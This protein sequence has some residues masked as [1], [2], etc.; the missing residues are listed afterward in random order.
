MILLTPRSTWY[1]FKLA[2]IVCVFQSQLWAQEK[3]D[4]ND[5][6]PK[7][8]ISEIEFMVG[9]SLIS[10]QVDPAINRINKLGMMAGIGL[11]HQFN[12]RFSLN[13]KLSYEQKGMKSSITSLNEDSIPPA[14]QEYI[15]NTTLS[16][17]TVTVLP[18]YR[19]FEKID[20]YVGIGPYVGYLISNKVLKEVYINDQ[21]VSKSG[22]RISGYS[23]Y[24]KFDYGI[25][26]LLGYNVKIKKGL[27]GSIQFIY[28]LGVVDVNQP[29]LSKVRN[30]T[31]EM[32][33]GI[34]INRNKH[35][36]P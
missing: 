24:K 19:P 23:Y 26:A 34:T 3:S 33:C 17:A 4:L 30:S 11:T 27:F 15:Q 13:A 6:I 29:M 1:L 2:S 7:R 22:G 32:L 25:A 31:Y 5:L 8:V 14:N 21:L 35:L 12:T 9:A 36:N 18:R 10:P 28:T 16:Y 20:C